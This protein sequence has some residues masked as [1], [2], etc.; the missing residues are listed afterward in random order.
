MST[1]AV[2]QLLGAGAVLV[3]FVAVQFRRTTTHST[4]YLWSNLLGG[5]VLTVVSLIGHQWGFF[6]LNLT[7][8][9]VAI[10]SVVALHTSGP[11]LDPR[12]G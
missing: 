8:A 12:Q 1:L 6:L 4:F 5:V 2:I 3:P 11:L 7:W 10:R 9:A